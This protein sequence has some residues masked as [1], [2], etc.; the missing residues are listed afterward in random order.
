MSS[1]SGQGPS[2]KS[3]GGSGS[4]TAAAQIDFKRGDLV[5]AKV[6]GYSWW[7]AKIG[8]VLKEKN[9]RSERKYK[10]DFIGD[11]TH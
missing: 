6:R 4:G 7:P 2:S 11:N 1:S 8:E 10:V 5:W 3:A 9:D